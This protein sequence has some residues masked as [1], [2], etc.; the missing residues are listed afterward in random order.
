MKKK[1]GKS[2][3]LGTFWLVWKVTFIERAWFFVFCI[4]QSMQKQGAVLYNKC[5]FR[6]LIGKSGAEYAEIYFC[7]MVCILGKNF[8]R[9]YFEI[10]FLFIPE[11]KKKI[12]NLFSAEMPREYKG[13]ANASLF[14]DCQCKPS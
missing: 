8:S 13:L 12:I 10:F 2:L 7:I 11:N 1:V 9:Q 3:Q 4:S 5:S 6:L 14:Y